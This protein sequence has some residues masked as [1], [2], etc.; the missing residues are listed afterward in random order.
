[1]GFSVATSLS[2]YM[3]RGE[4]R[5]VIKGAFALG[6]NSQQLSNTYR[7][8]YLSRLELS[9]LATSD[10][11][12]SYTVDGRRSLDAYA[13]MGG[14]LAIPEPAS[15]FDTY[16]YDA[17]RD[18][19]GF[20]RMVPDIGKR[21]VSVGGFDLPRSK[22]AEVERTLYQR[23]GLLGT[24]ISPD[25]TITLDGSLESLDLTRLRGSRLFAWT[26]SDRHDCV[27]ADLVYTWPDGVVMNGWRTYEVH[28]FDNPHLKD[29]VVADGTTK[30]YWD[31]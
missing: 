14:L 28:I 7:I 18:V 17:D 31:L 8:A 24:L 30:I 20:V 22:I 5:V 2:P 27:W 26:A 21:Y 15:A 25:V 19:N 13:S 6:M 3:G 11:G 23:H 9:G 16:D 29:R 1:M 4:P 10:T 12:F